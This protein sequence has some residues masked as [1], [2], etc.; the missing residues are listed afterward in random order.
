LVYSRWNEFR[1]PVFVPRIDR[2]TAEQLLHRFATTYKK[3]ISESLNDAFFLFRESSQADSV[4]Y[5]RLKDGN[6]LHAAV[7]KQEIQDWTRLVEKDAETVSS[8]FP[9][10]INALQT[11]DIK[12]FEIEF[13]SAPEPAALKPVEMG[14]ATYATFV[15]KAATTERLN[16]PNNKIIDLQADNTRLVWRN[17]A[18]QQFLLRSW[19]LLHVALALEKSSKLE[20]F[21]YCINLDSP[22]DRQS[23]MAH[24][25]V[26]D[27]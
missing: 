4:A 23:D 26:F 6:V 18:G 12:S 14:P 10:L 16:I 24:R 1:S 15:P 8:F 27:A 7:T 19:E 2:A 5:S 3:N 25:F 22:I 17:P 21:R 11:N 13:D 20:K 9:E